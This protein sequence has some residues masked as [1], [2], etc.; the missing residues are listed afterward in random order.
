MKILLI[1]DNSDKGW[2]QIIEKIFPVQEIIVEVALNSK[3]AIVKLDDK[4]DMIF[5]DVRLSELDQGVVDPTGFSGY[6]ILMKIKRDFL[7]VNFSTPIILVTASNKIWN[8]DAFKE[9][10][11]DG[12]YIKEHPDYIFDKETS[13]QNYNNLKKNFIELRDSG[14]RREA[15]WL[16]S[17]A[18]LEKI[19]EHSYFNSNE[20]DLNVKLRITEKLKLGYE[21]LFK[22]PNKLGIDVLKT[23]NEAIAFIIYWSIIEE[24]VKGCSS[25]DNWNLPSYK[26]TGN[27]KFRNEVFFIESFDEVVKLSIK[28]VN[29]AWTR[30]GFELTK[31]AID[32]N[33]L[34]GEIGLS[35]QVHALIA[36]YAKTD[37]D[38]DDI[39]RKFRDINT[40][41]NNID[42]IHSSILNIYEKE[43]VDKKESEKQYEYCI[44]QLDFINR[45]LYTI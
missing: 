22:K 9:Y 6:K 25:P 39:A 37:K 7:N 19:A 10:G 8:I 13:K 35:E 17:K 12:Y 34:K 41:R 2:K 33:Y 23:N 40:F 26:F 5:L 11:I 20:R 44:N 36:A 45:I 27:W 1:D 28:K 24:I 31:E 43:L 30:G 4:Y 16:L 18:I 3:E 14:D 32:E 38:F 42:F 21:Y 15:V 29:R